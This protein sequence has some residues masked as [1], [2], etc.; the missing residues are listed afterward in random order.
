MYEQGGASAHHVDGTGISIKG[1]LYSENIFTGLEVGSDVQ[2]LKTPM[3][4]ITE[5]RSFRDVFSIDKEAVA[6]VGRNVDDK[7][8]GW[9]FKIEFLTEM[10]NAKMSPLSC[11][12][13]P[14][15]SSRLSVHRQPLFLIFT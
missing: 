11:R 7:P 1:D 3:S 5:L 6:V 12:R 4:Q 8:L 2:R 14:L 9:I 13:Y 10:I 15:R